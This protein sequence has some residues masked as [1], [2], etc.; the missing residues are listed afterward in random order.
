MVNKKYGHPNHGEAGDYS[1]SI[2][3]LIYNN[4]CICICI[5]V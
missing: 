5:H 3:H 2:G 1:M 4:V